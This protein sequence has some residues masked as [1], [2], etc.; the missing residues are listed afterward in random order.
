MAIQI[1]G[2]SFVVSSLFCPDP[3]GQHSFEPL[4]GSIFFHFSKAAVYS[5]PFRRVLWQVPPKTTRLQQITHGFGYFSDFNPRLAG[6]GLDWWSPR[7][8]QR[9]P[10][11]IG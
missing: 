10:S 1:T 6:H 9:P 2:A 3:A 8:K 7:L 5:L 11:F 4:P